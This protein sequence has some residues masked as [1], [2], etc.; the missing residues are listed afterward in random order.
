MIANDKIL[1]EIKKA[2]HE[3]T[4]E[5]EVILFGSRVTGNIHQES[6][7]D[8]LVLT[9]EKKEKKIKK[10]I[11]NKLY[12]ISLSIDAFISLIFTSFDEWENNPAYYSLRKS[13]AQEYISI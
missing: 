9:K 12:P 5:A 13:I 10:E 1:N 8:I 6:D 7:W 11:Q 2:V 3:I 4:P